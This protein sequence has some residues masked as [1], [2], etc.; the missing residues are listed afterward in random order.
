MFCDCDKNKVQSLD[1]LLFEDTEDDV[2]EIIL[3]EKEKD[4]EDEKE[5]VEGKEESVD[6]GEGSELVETSETSFVCVLA[7]FLL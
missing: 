3:A 1:V 6:E 7:S 4:E 5:L 2:N